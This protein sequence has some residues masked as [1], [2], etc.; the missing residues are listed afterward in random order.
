MRLKIPFMTLVLLTTLPLSACST[1]ALQALSQAAPTANSGAA[2]V[3]KTVSQLLALSSEQQTQLAR[4]INS[5]ELLDWSSQNKSASAEA[6][7][8]TAT[9][10]LQSKPQLLSLMSNRFKNQAGQVGMG[11]GRTGGPGGL[12]P[13]FADIQSKYPELATALSAMQN[14]SPEE[15]RTQMDTLFQAHPEWQTALAPPQGMGGP[16]GPGGFG[17]PNGPMGSPP[18]GFVPGGSPPPLPIASPSA[19]PESK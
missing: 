8:T 5:Q 16:G 9:T 15:R 14:L 3:Q 17:S 1:A 11:P 10:L 12:P 18:P 2:N 13:N 4:T 7:Q 6:K 19:G